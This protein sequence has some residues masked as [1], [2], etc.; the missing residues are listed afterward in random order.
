MNRAQFTY[1]MLGTA[2]FW[3][4][5]RKDGIGLLFHESAFGTLYS[6]RLFYLLF[7]MLVLVC[8]LMIIVNRL[9]IA[10][11]F[12]AHVSLV[13][14][15]SIVASLAAYVM[16]KAE[17]FE[18]AD[19]AVIAVSLVLYAAWFALVV[20]A[21]GCVIARTQ[22]GSAL[23]PVFLGFLIA[24]PLSALSLLPYLTY[25]VPVAG[26]AVSGLFWMLLQ[27]S[28]HE[29][30]SLPTDL[31]FQD[32]PMRQIGFLTLFLLAGGVIRGFLNNGIIGAVPVPTM[33]PTH[34]VTA[35]TATIVMVMVLSRAHTLGM[36]RK[37]WG[38]LALLLFGGLFLVAFL[39][40]QSASLNS[41]ARTLVIAGRTCFSLFLWV[42]LSQTAAQ[43]RFDPIVLF[44]LF[45]V[46]GETISS[47]F[48]YL[49]VPALA[50]FL[51]VSLANQ[52]T[53]FSLITAFMLMVASFLFLNGEMPAEAKPSETTPLDLW[54]E[55]APQYGLT[56][57]ET[58]IAALISQGHSLKKIAG[59]LYLSPNTVQSYSKAL[60]KKL[61]VHK[62][63]DVID[64]IA[65]FERTRTEAL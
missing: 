30:T 20:P 36:Y 53:L 60:Y 65:D 32:I 50:Q 9:H 7:L 38:F 44:S 28:Y 49:L 43:R 35:I 26:P 14:I 2:F 41:F 19:K 23:L 22:R 56:E 13:F 37:I 59:T 6:A 57:R 55:L 39:G 27:L 25:I 46:I 5:F 16:T 4:V 31:S 17:L 47:L 63:Q 58:E 51:N 11:L 45:Y 29:G 62:K 12:A 61:D 15:V 21:W 33:I 8:S 3:P 64:L 52:L 48:S 54:R 40:Q 1:L 34:I 24:L 10:K 18:A 42:V